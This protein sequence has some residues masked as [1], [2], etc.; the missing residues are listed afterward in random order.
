MQL[1][2]FGLLVFMAGKKKKNTLIKYTK[3][4]SLVCAEILL[5]SSQPGSILRTK[6]QNQSI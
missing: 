6:G 1:L 3:F 2:Y 4:I 5:T